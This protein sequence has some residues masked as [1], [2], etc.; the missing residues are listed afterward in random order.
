VRFSLLSF[1]SPQ[2]PTS[3]TETR[4]FKQL[5]HTYL[6]V[7]HPLL[8][9]TQLRNYPYKRPQLRRVLEALIAP[10]SYR[11]VD[12]TTRRLVERNLR[13]SWCQGLRA[14][15]AALGLAGVGE[16]GGST[17]S[18]DQ[19]ATAGQRDGESTRTR[20][21]RHH[22]MRKHS[23]RQ[24][25]LDDS[26]SSVY[27]S[28][29]SATSSA[30]YASTSTAGTSV[31]S[32][33]PLAPAA[34]IVELG[35]RNAAGE[36]PYAVKASYGASSGLTASPELS[37]PPHSSSVNN[38]FASDPVSVRTG[39][40]RLAPVASQHHLSR[41]CSPSGRSVSATHPPLST[42][43]SSTTLTPSSHLVHPRPRSTSLSATSYRQNTHGLGL[44][45]S[46]PPPLPSLPIH[47][48][49][50]S[51]SISSSSTADF[52]APAPKARRRPPP[53]P[54]EHGSRPRTPSFATHTPSSTSS[55]LAT[56]LLG[57]ADGSVPGSPK[58]GR[59][60][61]PPP[62]PG[63]AAATGGT[64]VN[65]LGLSEGVRGLSIEY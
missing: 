2:H 25:S 14:A 19:V 47:P 15:D 31:Y 28:A 36:V 63:S 48:P 39:H 20:K 6:R 27:S 10:S 33:S 57:S 37:S 61:A 22:S 1:H 49:S 55:A 30:S 4:I 26:S 46:P 41:P 42:T 35:A 7:L 9:N 8:T 59:R 16:A 54:S 50:P 65:S 62:P 40:D 43:S 58:V 17:I 13:G 38:Y 18:V 21:H 56:P 32:S 45:D 64:G 12:P 44:T 29:P 23:R 24:T 11:D 3:R 60:R 51:P 34:S 5:K 53:P 52:S